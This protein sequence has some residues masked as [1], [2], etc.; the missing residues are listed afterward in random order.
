M[1]LEAVRGRIA[2]VHRGKKWIL[3]GE[4]AAGWTPV[5]DQLREWDVAGVMIVAGIAGVGDL[6]N[7]DSTFLTNT[8]GETMML[9]FRAFLRSV[10]HPSAELLAAIDAFD[11][12]GEA[13]VLNPG[14]S[15]EDHIAGR[16]VYGA[17]PREWRD[18]EDKMIVDE[19][20]DASGVS[21]AP[22]EVL[23][24]AEASAAADRL[25]GDLGTIWVADNLEG[26]HGGGEYVRWV[27]NPEDVPPAVDWFRQHARL[28]RV[29]P[30]LDGLPCS[31]HGFVTRDGVAVFNPVELFI[32]RVA[33][34][35]SLFYAQGGNFWNPPGDLRDEMRSAASSVGALLHDRYG[36]LGG[37]GIDG[38][39]T[40]DGFRPTELNPRLSLGH[41]VHARAADLPLGSIERLMIEGDIEIGAPDLEEAVLS[42]AEA[43]RRGGAIF[44]ARGDYATAKTGVVFNDDRATAVDPEEPSDATMEI[45]PAMFGTIVIVRFDSDRTP[46]GPSMAPRA[47]QTL[48]LARELWNVDVP[49]LEPAPDL[50]S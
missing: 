38:I 14:F 39:C 5:V 44:A 22:S 16:F 24:V 35:S 21:R 12:E 50:Y 40:A 7:A 47:L 26:W 4:A 36:Y 33:K 31:I 3:A 29:M 17:R 19:L 48:D 6:P 20:W 27:R 25:A 11:P 9:G 32:F 8:S 23:P 37:F 34:R 43:R 10:E 18:L 42:A 30:F 49:D 41:T 46:I 2:E 15:R 28:V 1:D 13:L 45:G